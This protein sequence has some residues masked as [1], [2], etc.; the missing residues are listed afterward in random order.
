MGSSLP[1]C[2]YRSICG[3]LRYNSAAGSF[4]T[5]KLCSRLLM[6]CGQNFCKNDKFGYL[7]PILGKLQVT[8]DRGWWLVGKPMV[9]FLFVLIER[10]SLSIMLLKLWGEMYTARLFSQGA[11]PLCT[12]ILPGQGRLPST[13]LG[14]RKPET[15]GYSMV[16]TASLCIP[17]FW[18]NTGV[19][20][21]DRWTNMLQHIQRLQSFAAHCKNKI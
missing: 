16:K 20:R 18:H 3:W 12:Q 7:N 6:V 15:L 19:W 2:W 5:M 13:I 10:F 4:S 21:T 9:D 17:S 8:H 11:R 1:K 14:I